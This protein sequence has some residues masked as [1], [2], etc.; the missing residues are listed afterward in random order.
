[1]P[2]TIK[3]DDS[4]KA[5]W[6]ATINKICKSN[7]ILRNP[8]SERSELTIIITQNITIKDFTHVHIVL[9]ACMVDKLISLNYKLK[10]QI[11]DKELFR[12]LVEDLK[13]VEYY[14]TS[15]PAPHIDSSKDYIFN[16]WKIEADKV[17]QHSISA[18][19]YFKRIYFSDL[20][21]SGFKTTIEELYHN[22]ADHSESNGIAYSYIYYD[23]TNKKIHVAVCDFGLG[24]PFTLK[25]A[26]PEKYKDDQEALRD[27]IELFVSAKTNSHNRGMGLDT[28]I[29][30][31]S[32]K[33][34]L[35][36]VS[37][38]GLLLCHP[39]KEP[40]KVF[41]LDFDFKGTL[42][43]FDLSTTAFEVEELIS[44]VNIG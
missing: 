7:I 23:S 21:L 30:N 18:T 20:D 28:V 17:D 4:K 26:N 40:I 8:K 25:R 14:N 38:T 34:L 32:N 9:F 16:L 27:S 43:Y 29:S 19:E 5:N 42:I 33:D 11:A 31:L 36:I 10:L 3:F 1:M 41:P 2:K 15:I 37:N 6:I 12:F 44:G 22:V 39:N 35:R 24:I 13:I